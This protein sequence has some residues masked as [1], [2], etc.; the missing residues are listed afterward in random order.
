MITNSV[1]CGQGGLGDHVMFSVIARYMESK[2]ANN[3]YMTAYPELFKGLP[4]LPRDK[5][6]IKYD[7]RVSYGLGRKNEKTSQF[8]DLCDR[9]EIPH[10]E[11]KMDWEFVNITKAF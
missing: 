10:I 4:I 6:L 11:Y 5:D 7:L 1:L 3:K 8:E 2:N 9:V